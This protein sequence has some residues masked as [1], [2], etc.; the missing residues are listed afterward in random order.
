MLDLHETICFIVNCHMYR[1]VLLQHPG[2]I[3]DQHF[4]F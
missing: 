2:T 4:A 1:A 3:D